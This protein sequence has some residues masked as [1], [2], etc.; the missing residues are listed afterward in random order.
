MLTCLELA[1]V[2]STSNTQLVTFIKQ[3]IL[4]QN[5][6][7]N[8]TKLLILDFLCQ[9]AMPQYSKAKESDGLVKYSPTEI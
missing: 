9:L 5:F 6:K 8:M 2:I 7:S 4:P 3:C 1:L